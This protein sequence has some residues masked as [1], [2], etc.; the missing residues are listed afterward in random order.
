MTMIENSGSSN[1]PWRVFQVSGSALKLESGVASTIENPNSC[2]PGWFSGE[3]TAILGSGELQE[4][5]LTGTRATWNVALDPYWLQHFTR[6]F[7]VFG[8]LRYFGGAHSKEYGAEVEVILNSR[9]IDKFG[10]KI[11]PPNHSDY[12][13]RIET[14]Q[15][16]DVWPLAACRTIYAWPIL[17]TSLVAKGVQEVTVQI[18][19]NV[20][21]DIDYVAIACQAEKLPQRVFLSHN[22][23]DKDVARKLAKDLGERGIGTW[24]DEAEIRLGDSLVEKIRHGID[25]VEYLVVLLSEASVNS[26]WVKKEVDIAMNQE[27]EGKK[28]KV[29]PVLLDNCDLPGFLKGKLYADL[30]KKANYNMVLRQIEQRLQP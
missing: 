3:S 29:L 28:V 20:S 19:K 16:P 1:A 26:E 30:T 9:Y 27:I 4:D 17:K 5:S 21:W 11:K 23:K 15:L 18:V 13:H 24:L 2:D 22:W 7:L 25:T 10:L 6:G 14:P 12:F 8:C